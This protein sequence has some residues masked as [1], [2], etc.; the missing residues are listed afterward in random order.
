[1]RCMPAPVTFKPLFSHPTGVWRYVTVH[2]ASVCRAA[3]Y[4]TTAKQ[5]THIH[6]LR[7]HP[8]PVSLTAGSRRPC[9]WLSAPRAAHHTLWP[10]SVPL[11]RP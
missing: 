7:H 1:M 8:S 6:S 5:H 4:T 11:Q 9:C 10:S 2:S 3:I